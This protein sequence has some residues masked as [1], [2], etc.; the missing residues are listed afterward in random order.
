[1]QGKEQLN[2]FGSDTL[3]SPEATGS[4]F[5]ENFIGSKPVD[6]IA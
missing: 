4:F 5:S 6:F 2:P 1:L 3:S